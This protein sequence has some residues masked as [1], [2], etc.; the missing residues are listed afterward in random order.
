MAEDKGILLKA[1]CISI[2]FGG[3]KAVT[4]FSCVLHRHELLG[5]I[6][7][8]GAGKT[9]VFN[10][11]SGVYT[12]TSGRITF[13]S[14]KGKEYKVNGMKP[15]QL[16]S[17]GISRT[18]QNIR[19]FGSMSVEDNVKIALHGQRKMNPF[20]ACFRT[21]RYYTEEKRQQE[22]AESILE[23]FGIVDK[24][25]ELSKNLPYGEQRKLEIARA[26]AADPDLL[27]LDE[28]AAGMN[29]QETD[30]LMHLISDIR[31]KFQTAILLIEHDMHFVMGICERLMVLDYGKTIAQGLPEEIQQNPAVI[32]AY[33]GQEAMIDA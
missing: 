27:L 12:P 25:Q 4:D 2:V 9:T 6:G 7:P 26:L 31:E 20:D 17:A 3:L 8:N 16:L 13:Y 14:S 15:H 33:L 30:S 23:L 32:K 29:P 21:P 24:R 1:D 5:L 22:K 11:L 28:P 10:M 19:L 18:F